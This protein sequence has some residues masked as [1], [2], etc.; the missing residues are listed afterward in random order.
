MTASCRMARGSR[1]K[2]SGQLKKRRLTQGAKSDHGGSNQ[3]GK[4]QSSCGTCPSTSPVGI[5]SRTK[6]H[7]PICNDSELM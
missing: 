6:S 7:A 2:L 1:F 4:I 5:D 3:N